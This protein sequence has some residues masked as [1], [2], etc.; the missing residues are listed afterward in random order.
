MDKDYLITAGDAETQLTWMDAKVGSWV[1]TPRHGKAVEINALWYNALKIMS[2]LAGN[3]GEDYNYYEDLAERVKDS[4]AREF[5]NGEKQCLFDVLT[6][7]FKDDRVRPNQILA[8]SLSF[9]AVDMEMARKIVQ[10]VWSELYTAYGLRTLT[11]AS[12]DYRGIYKGDQYSRDG[13]YHQ[14]TVWAWPLGHFITA[15]LKAYGYTDE[16]RKRALMFINPFRDHLR[17]AGVGS[18]SEIFD[19][20][21]PLTPRGCFAQAW[22]VGEILRSYTEDILVID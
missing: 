3:F 17:D 4:F 7:D 10:T 19:G 5:W 20:N 21:E 15:F 14:G 13:A 6:S 22:S 16:N 2:I 8:V 12:S 18:I 11:S 9:S 1:V